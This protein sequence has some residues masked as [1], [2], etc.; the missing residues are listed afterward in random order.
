ML[1]SS[2]EW[3]VLLTYII[4]LPDLQSAKCDLEETLDK[5]LSGDLLDGSKTMSTLFSKF[6]RN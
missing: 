2:M 1:N 6:C 3:R 5:Q 4:T